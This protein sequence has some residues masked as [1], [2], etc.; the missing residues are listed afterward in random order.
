[1]NADNFD[2][3]NS[4]IMQFFNGLKLKSGE[5]SIELQYLKKMSE[6][7]ERQ[8]E[9]FEEMMAEVMKNPSESYFESTL[10]NANDLQM[11]KEMFTSFPAPTSQQAED[12]APEADDLQTELNK[13]IRF[14]IK[15]RQKVENQI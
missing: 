10:S 5:E 3:M 11:M 2:I 7:P 8:N 12:Q 1:M 4:P 13:S 6:N 9:I 15:S 14:A